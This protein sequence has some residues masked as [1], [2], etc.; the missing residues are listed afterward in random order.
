M[1]LSSF[2]FSLP[3]NLI[4]KYP[5]THR[6][7]SRLMVVERNSGKISHLQLPDI[8]S[9]FKEGDVLVLNNTRVFPAQ[10]FGYKEKTGAKINVILVRELNSQHHLW[11]V[12]IEPA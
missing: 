2:E 3:A 11:D 1:K 8:L 12:V 7:E 9:F 5:L 10:I 4:T 6:E